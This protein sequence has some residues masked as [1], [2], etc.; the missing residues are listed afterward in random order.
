MCQ[1]EQDIAV[2]LNLLAVPAQA[3]FRTPELLIRTDE[4][5]GPSVH[6]FL[7]G[8]VKLTHFAFSPFALF[9]RA[10]RED[11][12]RQVV[13]QICVLL[14]RGLGED[15]RRVSVKRERA[16]GVAVRHQRK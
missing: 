11:P 14:N 15:I 1:F 2:N 5:D 12:I 16:K 3:L 7:E 10:E 9:A 8:R 6:A 4:F 13:G